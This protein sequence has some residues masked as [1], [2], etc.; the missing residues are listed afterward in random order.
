M[1]HKLVSSGDE[2]HRNFHY[3]QHF[4]LEIIMIFSI[5]YLNSSQSLGLKEPQK[6]A[7][8]YIEVIIL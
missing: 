8:L 2:I 6:H 1:P 4:A 7:Q 5:Y 3:Q